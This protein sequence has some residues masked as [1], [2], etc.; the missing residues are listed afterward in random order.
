[1]E[2]ALFAPCGRMYDLMCDLMRYQRFQQNIP[3]RGDFQEVDLR[4][5][6]RNGA[7]GSLLRR[8]TF[9]FSFNELWELAKRKIVW[10]GPTIFF[11]A[12]GKVA[13]VSA[14]CQSYGFGPP[15]FSLGLPNVSDNTGGDNELEV[16]CRSGTNEITTPAALMYSN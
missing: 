11:K 6:V 13:D 8:T 16:Y 15:V 4:A 14:V 12:K 5:G 7:V 2:Q 3:F 1:M 9:R 10:F